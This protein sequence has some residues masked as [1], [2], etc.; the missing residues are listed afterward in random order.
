MFYQHLSNGVLIYVS[1]TKNL[2][3]KTKFIQGDNFS[4]KFLGQI[5]NSLKILEFL[6]FA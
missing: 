6:Y 4:K 5:L 1:Q 2:N 3:N